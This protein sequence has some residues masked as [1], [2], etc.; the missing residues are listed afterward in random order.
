[1]F[2]IVGLV[3]VFALPSPWNVVGPACCLA[4]FIGEIGFWDR[5][6]RRHR[7]QVGAETLIG[8]PATVVT[9]CRPDG[10]VRVAGEIWEARCREGADQGDT[11]VVV[12]RDDLRL[13][14]ERPG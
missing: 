12:E 7:A 4:L 6:V 10:Q 1:M 2:L 5:T 11:V 14:V 13:L 8:R 3:L 9:P